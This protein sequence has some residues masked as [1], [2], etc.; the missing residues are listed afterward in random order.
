VIDYINDRPRPLALYIFTR[1][2]HLSDTVVA[3]TRSG[4]VAVNDC[5][6]HAV[7]HDLP[8]GG[9]GN[10]GMGQYHGMEGFMEFSKLRPVFHQA[11]FSSTA[12]LTPPYGAFAARIY[13]A[14][15]KFPWLS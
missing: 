10:S 7:Q 5:A 14:I 9:I 1:D 11:P 8:F 13:Q 4:G 15:K 12:A 2:R 6:L 3:H